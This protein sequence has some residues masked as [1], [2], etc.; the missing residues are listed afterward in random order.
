M[1]TDYLI[2]IESIEA[3]GYLATVPELPELSAR[4]DTVDEADR[5]ITAMVCDYHESLRLR[6]DFEALL[7]AVGGQP[8]DVVCTAH[9]A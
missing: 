4:G 3:G 5:N 6:A 2:V 1:I 7:D 9:A 8:V